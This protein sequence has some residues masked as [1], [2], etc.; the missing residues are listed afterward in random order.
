MLTKDAER[1][2]ELI[3]A[4][5]RVMYGPPLFWGRSEIYG[6]LI[7]EDYSKV[8][9]S[10]QDLDLMVGQGITV[11]TA[12]EIA[13]KLGQ[14][15]V[16]Y[17]GCKS[18]NY[19]YES[20][21]KRS[22]DLKELSTKIE[23]ELSCLSKKWFFRKSVKESAKEAKE[24]YLR[25]TKNE[26]NGINNSLAKLEALIQKDPLI[27]RYVPTTQ[28]SYI[29]LDD[30]VERLSDLHFKSTTI[31]LTASF[32]GRIVSVCIQGSDLNSKTFYS[33]DSKKVKKKISPD[34][35]FELKIENIPYERLTQIED[36]QKENKNKR[37][38]LIV[39]N[40]IKD[41]SLNSSLRD[42]N[43][44]H[45]GVLKFPD[46]LY[47]IWMGA[48]YG[49]IVLDGT[50]AFLEQIEEE[51]ELPPK[52]TSCEH[53]ECP[54]PEYTTV[55]RDLYTKTIKGKFSVPLLFISEDP[56]H[57]GEPEKLAPF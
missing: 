3:S 10:K 15:G 31:E 28:G 11:R 14:E 4:I 40:G 57:A 51:E 49:D 24:K 29:A 33:Y 34:S 13:N 38:D 53:W 27:E 9:A 39:L 6:K 44:K 8:I 50:V 20:L 23:K 41:K 2:D 37:I 42:G 12:D 18:F 32:E 16:G 7:T 45:L 21:R 35:N 19:N 43:P 36:I 17:T 47:D 48:A 46:R 56:H 55:H 25:A 5:R 1:I 30:G 52:W 26:L 22:S 54:S